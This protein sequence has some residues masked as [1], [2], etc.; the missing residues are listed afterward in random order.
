MTQ[1]GSVMSNP[2]AFSAYQAIFFALA[3]FGWPMF[4]TMNDD[5]TP[6]EK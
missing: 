5:T 4:I 2:F 1:R 6:N 3:I